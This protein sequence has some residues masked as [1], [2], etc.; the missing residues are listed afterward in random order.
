MAKFHMKSSSQRG[1]ST[2]DE[3][4]NTELRGCLPS[5]LTLP[6][7]SAEKAPAVKVIK[8]L[9]FDRQFQEQKRSQKLSSKALVFPTKE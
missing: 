8:P 4:E 7:L 2:N 5:I 9:E 3:H 6:L 1:H